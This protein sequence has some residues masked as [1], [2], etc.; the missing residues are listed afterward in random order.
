[1]HRRPGHGRTAFVMHSKLY[2]RL[3]SIEVRTLKV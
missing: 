1:M 2:A 3:S